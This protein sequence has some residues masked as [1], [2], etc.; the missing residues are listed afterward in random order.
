[1]DVVEDT[2]QGIDY[3]FQLPAFSAYD[4][5]YLYL[6]GLLQSFFV[7]QDAV[8]N[9]HQS[10]VGSKIDWKTYPDIYSIRELRND[11]IGHPTG[12]GNGASF[13][14]IA[15]ISINKE[16]FAMMSLRDETSNTIR[17][18]LQDIRQTQEDTV[19]LILN[20]ILLHL[21]TEFMKHK[22]KFKGQTL[23]S[24]IPATYGYYIEKVYEGI[25]SDRP[26]GSVNLNMIKQTHQNIKDGISQRYGGEDVLES[27]KL[28]T[29][30]ID[31]VLGKL[32]TYF[33]DEGAFQK[34]DAEV[35]FDAFNGYFKEMRD[36]LAEID[37]EFT[38]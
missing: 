35:F 33:A 37:K 6:Y 13:H 36:I 9:L 1:M 10:L 5:G 18:K 17:V 3:F 4:G 23:M 2:Q 24:L 12:R 32:T 27:T 7:Q 11:A 8:S 38:I 20:E 34:R 14:F 15:R 31:Y 22:N 25:S 28:I 26:L 21:E 16:S 19:V 30:K 29:D